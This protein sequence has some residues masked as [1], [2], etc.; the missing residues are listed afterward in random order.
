MS[1]TAHWYAIRTRSRAEKVVRDQL[2]ARQIEPLLPLMSRVSQWKDRKKVVEW[3][4]FPGYCFAKFMTDQKLIVLQTPGLVE[5]VSGVRGPEPIPEDEIMSVMRVVQSRVSHVPWAYFSDGA[6]VEVIRGPLQ[7]LRGS[8]V[9]Q[10]HGS[11][12]VIRVNLIQ[13][14]TAVE[15]EADDVAPIKA[16]AEAAS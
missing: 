12:L 3:P 7:G 8:F 5:I 11:R 2:I 4:L 15:I 13:Q 14:A 1:I 9:R 6:L 10:A 16:L